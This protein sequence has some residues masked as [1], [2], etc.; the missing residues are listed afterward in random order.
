MSKLSLW[1]LKV[2][3]SLQSCGRVLAKPAYLFTAAFTAF[4]ISALVLWSLNLGLVR[5]VLFESGIRLA[6]KLDFF[7]SVYGGILANYSN[8]QALGI[9]LFSLLF[10]INIAFIIFVIRRQGFKSIPKKSGV[11]GLFFAIVGGGCIACGTSIIA[12]L[13]V[14]LGAASAPFVKSLGS[15]F[16]WVGIVLISYS[17]YKLGG[18]CSFVL[19]QEKQQKS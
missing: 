7:F 1:G 13:I 17:I 11:G 5:F 2:K 19:A 10:G 4:V 16:N 3:I 18:V 8:V 15:I 12:P 14:S 9:I 6:D